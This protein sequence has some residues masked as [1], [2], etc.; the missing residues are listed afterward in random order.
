MSA[1]ILSDCEQSE[2]YMSIKNVPYQ[3]IVIIW[4]LGNSGGHLWRNIASC[5]FRNFNIS[6][7]F[8]VLSSIKKSTE[9][10]RSIF[11]VWSHFGGHLDFLYIF[12]P[13]SLS[14]IT[15]YTFVYIPAKFHNCRK[16]W[17]IFSKAAPLFTNHIDLWYKH[18]HRTHT[19]ARVESC[20][21][22]RI[23]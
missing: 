15:E 9:Q 10:K 18:G 11:Q 2:C 17:T 7:C 20:S 14:N 4:L 5:L 19:S 6:L 8:Y 21:D 13:V 1:N 12:E 3:E 22:G 16:K 23:W